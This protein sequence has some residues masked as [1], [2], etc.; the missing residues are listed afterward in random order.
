MAGQW[1]KAS[2]RNRARVLSVVAALLV[3]VVTWGVMAATGAIGSPPYVDLTTAG[4]N[5]PVNG[6]IWVEGG[7]G[8]GTGQFDPFLTESTNANT[9]TATTAVRRRR[10]RHERLQCKTHPRSFGSS[11]PAH[12]IGTTKYREFYLDAND[13][14]SDDY[15]SID[16]FKLYLDNQ[17][18]LTGYN[19]STNTFATDDSAKAFIYDL[20]ATRCSCDR[21]HSRPG[22][23]CPTS[24]LMFRQLLP[25]RLLLRLAHVQ[26][27]R[28]PSRTKATFYDHG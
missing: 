27:V 2:K 18:S 1:R 28:D 3:G 10:H 5:V 26:P 8:A 13:T 24:S 21:E 17:S 22:A 6:A 20:G 9:G 7:G 16:E 19:D 4:A 25:D 23:A 12:T 11:D 15:M 14:G